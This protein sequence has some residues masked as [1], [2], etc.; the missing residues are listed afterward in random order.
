MCCFHEVVEFCQNQD[1]SA[2][3]FS[4]KPD[5]FLEQITE[6][7][8]SIRHCSENYTLASEREKFGVR[9][10][11][12]SKGQ[13]LSCCN[14]EEQEIVELDSNSRCAESDNGMNDFNKSIS[15]IPQG[16]IFNSIEDLIGN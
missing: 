13:L 7:I 8:Y 2:I 16:Q 4:V 3:V 14:L 10:S 5:Q 11:L 1:I 12:N 9:F 15:N 6:R